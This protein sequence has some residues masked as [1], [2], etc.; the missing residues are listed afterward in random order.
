MQQHFGPANLYGIPTSTASNFPVRKFGT[1]QDVSLD[2]SYSEK[3]LYGQ[4]QFA[5]DVAR[6]QAKIT[7]KAKLANINA[8]MF[9]DLFLNGALSAGSQKFIY[10]ETAAIP[11]T[12]YQVTTVNS[13]NFAQDLGVLDLTTGLPMT[14]VSSTPATG[15]YLV[16]AGTG[17]YTFAA[18]DTGHQVAIDY[19]YNA[20]SA[21]STVA[22][23]NVL[24]GTTPYFQVHFPMLRTSTGQTCYFKLFKCT[25]TKLAI[26]TKIEDFVIPEFDF[27]AV[28][29]TSGNVYT[30]TSAE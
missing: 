10:G 5:V 9:N 22:V 2:I 29:D 15:Q 6:G 11:G 30:M 14:R 27:V 24:A 13:A 25:S 16:N 17:A 28:A 1:L 12:P 23:T 8:A 20:A 18:A 21:G 26:A 19:M 3:M 4:N 7:G